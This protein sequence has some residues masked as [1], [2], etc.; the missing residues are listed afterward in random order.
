MNIYKL[1]ILDEDQEVPQEI[2]ERTVLNFIHDETQ[3]FF[4]AFKDFIDRQQKYA[5]LGFLDDKFIK[6]RRTKE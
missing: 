3:P 6:T 4:E 5:A 2:R 1:V